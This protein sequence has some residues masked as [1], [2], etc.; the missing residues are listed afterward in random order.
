VLCLAAIGDKA[1]LQRRHNGEIKALRLPEPG[2]L[3]RDVTAQ[4]APVLALVD[5][6][7]L[8]LVRNAADLDAPSATPKVVLV[9]EGADYLAGNPVGL[10]A[11]QAAGIRIVTLVHLR[12]SELGDVQTEAEQHGGLSDAGSL[13]VAQMNRLGLV[14]D[15]AH[16]SY[17]TAR[18]AVLASTAPVLISHANL[19][20][21]SGHPRNVPS[22]L[23]RLV[24]DGGGVVCA[25]PLDSRGKGLDGVAAAV[26]RVVDVAGVE[27]AGLATDIGGLCCATPVKD[28]AGYA[29]LVGF[30]RNDGMPEA[31]LAPLIG[32]NVRRLLREVLG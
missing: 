6:G 30:L 2:E 8:A 12:T 28:Y 17:A 25:W 24:A 31:T 23:A 14:V 1:T 26:R 21:G 19:D 13:V 5:A 3:A 7:G 22:R 10:V 16:A 4:L 27:H 9:V 20:D 15:L 32:G 11:S 29:R 18:G